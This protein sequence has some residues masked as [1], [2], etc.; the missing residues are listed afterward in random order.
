MYPVA[1]RLRADVNHRITDALC[2]GEKNLLFPRDSERQ[3]IHQRILRITWLEHYLSS[4][5]RDTEAI[6]VVCNPAN[7]GIENATIFRCFLFTRRFRWSDFAEPQRI[8]YGNRPRAHGENVAHDPAN[9]CRRA[10]ERFHVTRVIVR[11]DLECRDQS[12]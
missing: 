11:F 8:E 5:G 2:L 9:A 6:S 12:V 10:L 1:S 7:H 4:N 3:S